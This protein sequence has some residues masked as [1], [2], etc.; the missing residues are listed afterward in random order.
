M[1]HITADY[2]DYY[3]GFTIRQYLASLL[4]LSCTCLDPS[5]KLVTIVLT[6]FTRA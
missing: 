1:H 3:F 5:I 4:L 6:C 2:S